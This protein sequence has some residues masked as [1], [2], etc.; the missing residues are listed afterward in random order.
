M[1]DSVRNMIFAQAFF[2]HPDNQSFVYVIVKN[3]TERTASQL[4]VQQRNGK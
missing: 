4:I 2:K 1:P 3:R